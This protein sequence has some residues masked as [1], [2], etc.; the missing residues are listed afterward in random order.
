MRFAAGLRIR[1]SREN[2]MRRRVAESIRQL[3]YRL[4]HWANCL[5][6]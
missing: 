6:G 2:A 5:E 3:A 1:S 4:L